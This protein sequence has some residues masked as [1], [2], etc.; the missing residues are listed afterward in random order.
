MKD[1]QPQL[2]MRAR[3]AIALAYFIGI[4]LIAGLSLPEGADFSRSAEQTMQVP[5]TG[6]SAARMDTRPRHAQANR[7][8]AVRLSQIRDR[9]FPR[10][11]TAI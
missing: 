2:R 11:L 6:S 7:K 8:L 1:L 3:M 4:T 9:N 5:D 10:V